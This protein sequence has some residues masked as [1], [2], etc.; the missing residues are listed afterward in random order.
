MKRITTINKF[1]LFTVSL[2]ASSW[3]FGQTAFDVGVTNFAFTPSSLSISVGDTVRWTNISGTHNVNGTIATFPSNPV[4]FAN[5]ADGSGAWV[6]EFV[7]TTAGNYSYQCGVHGASMQGAITVTATSGI[8][9][10]EQSNVLVYPNPAKASFTVE[11][12]QGIASVVVYDV[13]GQL[14][15]QIAGNSESLIVVDSE[16]LAAGVYSYLI[17]GVNGKSTQG[18][19]IISK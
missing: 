5:P 18:S 7:F 1:M 3:S 10:N 8:S 19:V 4:T 6:F 17:N 16:S 11:H 12:E 15:L 14:I 9:E 13:K 2:L